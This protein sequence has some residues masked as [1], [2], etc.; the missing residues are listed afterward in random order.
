MTSETREGGVA[1]LPCPFCGK[2]ASLVS[3]R[4]NYSQP[5][6]WTA[7][8]PTCDFSLNGESTPEKAA[9]TWNRRV[10]PPPRQEP[11]RA[12]C[13]VGAPPAKWDGS[14]GPGQYEGDEDC[15]PQ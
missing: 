9:G 3:Y 2:Q 8:C 4:G 1:L 13:D 7:Y 5:P 15:C 6:D 10:P 14:F 12:E 11:Q